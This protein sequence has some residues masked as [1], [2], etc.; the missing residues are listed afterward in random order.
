LVIPLGDVKAECPLKLPEVNR[1]EMKRTPIA[2]CEMIA[3]VHQA[4]EEH[5]VQHAEHVAG[6]MG[7]HLAASPQEQRRILGGLAVKSRIV[8]DDAEHP[9]A[10]VEQRFAEY[11]APRVVRVEVVHRNSEHA[12]GIRR[13]TA[14][15]HRENIPR[16]ELRYVREAIAPCRDAASLDNQSGEQ[17]HFAHEERAPESLELLEQPRVIG[18]EVSDRS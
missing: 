7:E 18:R 15:K 8:A 3:P 14:G 2:L 6:L 1:A 11:E 4:I 5:A 12:P 10:V 9:D 13:K 17:A 16:L